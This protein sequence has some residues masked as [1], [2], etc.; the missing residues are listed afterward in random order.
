MTGEEVSIMG[1]FRQLVAVKLYAAVEAISNGHHIARNSYLVF[2][3]GPPNMK[4]VV[5]L[6]LKAESVGRRSAARIAMM[7]MTT[8]NSVSVRPVQ[9]CFRGIPILVRRNRQGIITHH[10]DFWAMRT[11]RISRLRSIVS[12]CQRFS[13]SVTLLALI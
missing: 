7:T 2:G 13:R 5:Q 11:L 3:D 12:C 10:L 8:S 1:S 6:T 4:L 9:F